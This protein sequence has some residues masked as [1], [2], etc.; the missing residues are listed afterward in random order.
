MEKLLQHWTTYSIFFI[1]AFLFVFLFSCTTSP[2][3]EHYPFWFHGDS[4]IFQEMG[5]CLV[6]GG[7]PYVDLF[8]HKGPVLWFIQAFGIWISPHWGFVLLQ[9]IFLF[10]TVVIWHKTIQLFIDKQTHAFL[11][12]GLGLFFLMCFYSR[13]NLCEEWS[14]PFISWPIYLLIKSIKSGSTLSF[15]DSLISGVCIGV[16]ALIRMNNMAPFL[17]FMLWYFIMLVKESKWRPVIF[18][19]L[20]IA[21]GVF[22]VF[23]PCISFYYFKAGWHGV[24][25][26]LYGTFGFNFIYIAGKENWSIV[27]WLQ[28]YIPMAGFLII[29]CLCIRKDNID[30]T[31]PTIVSYIIT[32][33]AIGNKQFWHYLMIII[34]IIIVTICLLF[35]LSSKSGFVILGIVFI[36][37]CIVGYN[38]VDCLAHRLLGNPVNTELNDGFHRFVTSISPEERESIYN[39]NLNHMGAGLFAD[40]RIC[41]CNR[42]LSK[43]HYESSPRL[44][45]YYKTHGIKELQPTWILTQSPR[46]VLTDDYMA[47]N[48]T[49]ADSIPGGEFDNIWCWKKNNKELNQ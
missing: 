46:P 1:A 21:V 16:L 38:A 24:E 40:E 9:T 26:M 5:V 2:M 12:L 37:C 29:T 49:L 8:D 25:E 15:L 30:I 18:N 14:L 4:G 11:I 39:E 48:Y 34:P 19:A 44:N 33:L 35:K 45:D 10:F 3:Y 27:Q 42:F 43:H 41:Q 32:F 31:V 6:K 7:T 22:A 28:Y 23:I 47:C 17:G 20:S 13:G 36:L